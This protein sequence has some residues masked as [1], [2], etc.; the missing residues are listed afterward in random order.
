MSRRPGQKRPVAVA[1]AVGDAALADRL[2]AEIG[3]Q[4]D[5]SLADRPD[6]GD[7]L[8]ITASRL[9]EVDGR[10]TAMVLLGD[11][12]AAEGLGL[13]LR[14]LLPADADARLIIGAVRLVARGLLVM[15]E[16]AL[17]AGKAGERGEDEPPPTEEQIQLTPREREVLELL[18]AGASN[19]V[20]ARRLGVS[21][22]TAKFHVASLFRKLG[23]SG[24]LEAVGIGL[25]TGLLMV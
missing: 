6:N 8:V 12:A 21:V 16:A 23:A 1:V 10:R 11:A 3:I 14:A 5:L 19:K 24:R 2:A 15:P 20:I 25:R 18:A 22:H 9:A 7:V 4:P 13:A 17:D